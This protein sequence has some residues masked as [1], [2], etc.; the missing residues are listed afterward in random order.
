MSNLNLYEQPLNERIRS[1]L[2]LQKLFKQFLF[3]KEKSSSWDH[4]I[5]VNSLND[6]LT[7]STRSDIKLEALKELER[8]HIKLERLAQRPNVD[9]TQ[10]KNLLTKQTSV[11]E[12][13]QSSSGQIGQAL[14][15]V[16][17]LNS[18]KQKSSVPGCICD[19]DLP[20]YQY[21]MTRHEDVRRNNL[22]SWFNSFT[23]LQNA[24]DLILEVLRQSETHTEEIA[25]KGFFQ[26][27]LDSNQTV[28]LI[29]IGIDTDKDYYPEISAG[30]QRFSIR[31]LTNNAPD[32]RPEQCQNDVTFNLSMCNI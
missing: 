2:R 12:K 21:W 7:F 26:K 17:L 16:E 18:I 5:A 8:Q 15:S 24:V 30:K 28:Q 29:Q 20:A 11:I 23:E 4:S 14:Q 9:H 19:F 6:I 22:E 27:N 25:E 32:I 31:F 3:H 13:L 10:L 1:F